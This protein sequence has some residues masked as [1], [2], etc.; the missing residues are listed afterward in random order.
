[1][2]LMVEVYLAAIDHSATRQKECNRASFA[3]SN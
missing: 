3:D 1:M 2:R